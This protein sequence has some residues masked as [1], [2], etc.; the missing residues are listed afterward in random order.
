MFKLHSKYKPNGDQPQAIDK[1]VNG[2]KNGEKHLGLLVLVKHSQHINL[3]K[4]W[5][6]QKFLF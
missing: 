3:Q 2:I 6:G 4:K 1:V 5:V